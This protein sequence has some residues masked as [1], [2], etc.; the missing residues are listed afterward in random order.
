MGEGQLAV[1]PA[2]VCLF[3]PAGLK[4]FKLDLF[5]RI[6]R[7]I[8]KAGGFVIAHDAA[9]LGKLPADIIPIIGCQ[10]ESTPLIAEWRRTGRQWIYW[11]RGY[12]RRVFATWLPRGSD[13]G[14]YRWHRNG[15][16]LQ[17]IR[18]VPDDRW[19]ATST[20]VLPWRKNGRH[21][22]IAAPT[23]TYCRFHRCESW[24]ADTIDALARVTDRQLVIRDKETKRPLQSDLDGAHCLVTHASIAAVESVI[25]GCPVFVHP[26]SAAALVGRTDFAQIEKPAYPDRQQWL[27][28]L[29]YSQ[30]NE[31]ELIDG[32]LWKLIA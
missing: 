5:E 29:A 9:L 13:G 26:D 20:D 21:I 17:Q 6:G 31:T 32:T 28:S 24:I 12:N 11:D 8:Q 22:V 23:R 30:F 3:I 18:D 25:L 4:R 15:F 27:N 2:K 16:Q 7:H 19:R 1:D 14:M 10:P